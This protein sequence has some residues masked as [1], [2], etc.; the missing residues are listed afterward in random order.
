MKMAGISSEEAEQPPPHLFEPH[1]AQ[2]KTETT[3]LVLGEALH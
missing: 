2:K 3:A 1:R